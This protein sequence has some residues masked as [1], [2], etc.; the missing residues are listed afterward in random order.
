MQV[1]LDNYYGK[2][3]ENY[4]SVCAD[5]IPRMQITEGDNDIQLLASL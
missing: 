2:Q 5:R 1:M 3:I 4:S